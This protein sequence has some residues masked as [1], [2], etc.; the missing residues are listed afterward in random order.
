MQITILDDVN[1]VR[2]LDLQ[3]KILACQNL[4]VSVTTYSNAIHNDSVYVYL[5][6]LNTDENVIFAPSNV[7]LDRNLLEIIKDT[8]NSVIVGDKTKFNKNNVGVIEYQNRLLSFDY[9]SNLKFTG[10]THFSLEAAKLYCKI[11]A[12]HSRKLFFFEIIEKMAF[13]EFDWKVINLPVIQLNKKDELNA[14]INAT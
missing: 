14:Y 2:A 12:K 11:A 13:D 1:K 8:P 7:I 3:L 6:L 9:K 5:D 4:S 10:I